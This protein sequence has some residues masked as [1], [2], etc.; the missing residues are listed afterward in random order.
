MRE[1]NTPKRR[2][3]QPFRLLRRYVAE[4]A[5]VDLHGRRTIALTKAGNFANRHV[6]TADVGETLR[7]ISFQ[8]ARAAN[9]TGHIHTDFGHDAWRWR[10]LEMWIE[11]RDR[12]NAR[13][14]RAGP[15]R[16][17]FDLVGGKVAELFL[18]SPEVVVDQTS[19]IYT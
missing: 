15:L 16:H 19:I 10:Q 2:R 12:M 5:I 6:A 13:N 17:G 9:V 7:Q 4:G 3:D 11:A 8:F 18:N 14:R 1:L